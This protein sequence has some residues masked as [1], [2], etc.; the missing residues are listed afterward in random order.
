[1]HRATSR[2]QGIDF[3]ERGQRICELEH[4]RGEALRFGVGER[5]DCDRLVDDG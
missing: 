4:A 3:G 2:S 1:M 5:G